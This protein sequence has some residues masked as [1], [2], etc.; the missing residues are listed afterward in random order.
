M[1]VENATEELNTSTDRLQIGDKLWVEVG[2]G[3]IAENPF[4]LGH[5][6]IHVSGNTKPGDEVFVEVFSMPG[7]VR[8]KVMHKSESETDET[9]V[10]DHSREK[11]IVWRGTEQ[12]INR[13]QAKKRVEFKTQDDIRGSKNDLLDGHL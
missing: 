10:P 4:Q 12:N 6:E 1:G 13:Q 7:E 11:A 8:A 9:I 5:D 2:E 3:G